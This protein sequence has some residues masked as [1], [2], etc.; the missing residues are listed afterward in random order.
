[1][2]PADQCR[3][4]AEVEL[5]WSLP[6]VKDPAGV[7]FEEPPPSARAGDPARRLIARPW[8]PIAAGGQ[9][10]RSGG[11]S[12]RELVDQLEEHLSE[13]HEL[14]GVFRLHEHDFVVRLVAAQANAIDPR[15]SVATEIVLSVEIFDHCTKWRPAAAPFSTATCMSSF[16]RARTEL[17]NALAAC[18]SRASSY[19]AATSA[20]S[21][22]TAPRGRGPGTCKDLTG[23]K[24]VG[25]LQLR[26]I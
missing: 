20:G 15:L 7:T 26:Q 2:S 14:V 17:V 10:L 24:N 13:G 6:E 12:D 4:A 8:P 22:R 25:W 3:R 18:A 1:M 21:F 9:G 19:S 16:R 11:R 5:L 23:S